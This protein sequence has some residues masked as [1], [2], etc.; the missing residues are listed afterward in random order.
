MKNTIFVGA[1]RYFM[2][3]YFSKNADILLKQR[4]LKQKDFCEKLGKSKSNWENIVKTNNLE[5]LSKIASI[6]EMDIEEVIGLNRPKFSLSGS[7][8]INVKIY[9]VSKKEDLSM[10]LELLEQLENTSKSR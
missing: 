4:H 5:M 8:K 1:S 10:F 3:T 7:V 2:E 9:E 6:L